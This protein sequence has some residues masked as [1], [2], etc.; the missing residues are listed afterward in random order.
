MLEDIQKGFN[1]Y[2]EVMA[3]NPNPNYTPPPRATDTKA[4]LCKAT[5]RAADSCGT[6]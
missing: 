1:A 4:S 3:P 2:L 6:R 5:G